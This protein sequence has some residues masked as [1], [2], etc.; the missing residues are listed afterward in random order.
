MECINK[1]YSLMQ[2]IKKVVLR[3]NIDIYKETILKLQNI[4]Q[5]DNIKEIMKEGIIHGW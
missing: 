4:L 2:R 5:Y 3:I 1:S